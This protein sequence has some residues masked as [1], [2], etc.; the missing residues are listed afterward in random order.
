VLGG[1]FSIFNSKRDSPSATTVVISAMGQTSFVHGY[2]S[3]NAFSWSTVAGANTALV[4]LNDTAI[5][6]DVQA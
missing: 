2:E 6:D 4:T 1:H 3:E 5:K